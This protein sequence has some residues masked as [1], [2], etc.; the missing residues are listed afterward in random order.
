MKIRYALLVAL[1]L[2]TIITLVAC[3]GEQKPPLTMQEY[4]DA[5]VVLKDGWEERGASLNDEISRKA[6]EL[7]TEI[8]YSD[9]Y[10]SLAREY[11]DLYIQTFTEYTHELRSLSPP[12]DLEDLHNS[13]ILVIEETLSIMEGFD[14]WITTSHNVIEMEDLILDLDHPS[15]LLLYYIAYFAS[16][17]IG[18][19]VEESVNACAT[20][21]E[22]LE[23]ELDKRYDICI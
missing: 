11:T 8:E 2:A 16:G 23:V 4:A 21:E 17:E 19:D 18:E 20:L 9:N 5:M 10:V 22:T 12:S 6:S 13:W 1:A 3:G 15:Y 14:H 7:S